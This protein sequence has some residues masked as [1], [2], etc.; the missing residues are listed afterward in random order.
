[1]YCDPCADR[2]DPI[3]VVSYAGT[4]PAHLALSHEQQSL[5]GRDARQEVGLDEREARAVEVGAR[6][7]FRRVL[8][9]R[10]RIIE[11][12]VVLDVVDA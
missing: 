1:M 7:E 9:S 3:C 10:G 8:R 4:R 11:R 5:H 2:P 6:E 12:R